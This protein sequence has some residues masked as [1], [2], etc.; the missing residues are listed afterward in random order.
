VL[1]L[2]YLRILRRRWIFPVIGLVL[3]AVAGY[4][5]APGEGNR[6]ITYTSTTTLL[7]NPSSM[8]LVNLDQ[9]ALL[10]TTGD[11]P[12]RAA[13]T[14][15]TSRSEA[16]SG[17]AAGARLETSSLVIS[18]TKD[19]AQQAEQT[20]AAFTDALLADLVEDDLAAYQAELDHTAER[21]QVARGELDAID[22]RLAAVPPELQ[23]ASPIAIERAT[24]NERLNGL[25]A[26]LQQLQDQGEPAPPIDLIERSPGRIDESQ[27]VRAPDGKPE[28]AALLGFFGL[29]LGAAA[30]IAVDRLDTRIRGKDDAEAAFGAPVIAEIPPLPGGQK[31]SSELFALTQPASPL[32]EAYRSL[33]TVVLYSAAMA[34]RPD[35]ADSGQDPARK[36][37][38]AQHADHDSQVVLITSPGA[39][40]GKTTTAAHLGALLAEVGKS[41]LVVSADF[42]RPRIHELFDTVCEPGL[43]DCLT[44]SSELGIADLDIE[45]TVPGV[46]LLP[47]GSPVSNPAPFLRE[48]AQLIAA[49]RQ[50]FDYIIIDTAPLLVANDA[51][52]LAGVADMVILLCRADRTTRDAAARTAEVLRRVEAPVLGAV[53]IA[54]S[55]TPTAYRYYKY[56][57]YYP[58]GAEETEARRARSSKKADVVLDAPEPEPS[59][60]GGPTH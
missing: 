52:E 42:R 22:R 9:L 44:G 5:T 43:T 3:A 32:V 28:R 15:G 12:G 54:P 45:T 20:A 11:V 25:L 17:V 26:S 10:V 38:A 48:T 34:E 56:R 16:L 33:R 18:A 8:A 59:S 21:I 51:T 23:A 7:S 60:A 47:S 41:V 13:E 27:G 55:D 31:T 30:A 6:P 50:L 14:L 24:T 4:L 49:A 53:V 39:G 19:T 58:Y 36:T 35:A 1:F 2:D 29:L 40:E 37:G 46:K 57:D